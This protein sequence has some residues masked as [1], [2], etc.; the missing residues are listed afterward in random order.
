MGIKA[1]VQGLTTEIG[2]LVDYDLNRITP[3][4]IYQAAIQGDEIAQDIFNRAGFYIG[5]AVA[6]TMAS[7]SP[8]KVVIGGGVAQAGDLLLEPIR[9]TAYERVH[10]M[11]AS[12]VEIVPAKLGVNAGMIGSALWASANI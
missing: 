4:V 11:P 3:K 2:R 12:Q 8:R 1:V 5:I 6:N 9:K 7:V 10:I